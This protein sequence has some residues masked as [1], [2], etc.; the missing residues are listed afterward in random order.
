MGHLIWQRCETKITVVYL[1]NLR[2]SPLLIP[3]GSFILQSNNKVGINYS[4]CSLTHVILTLNWMI[5]MVYNIKPYSKRSNELQLLKSTDKQKHSYFSFNP[6]FSEG[7]F[8]LWSKL[9]LDVTVFCIITFDFHF[10]W[11]I[12]SII[13]TRKIFLNVN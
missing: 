12:I 10:T 6:R 9:Q 11:N 1:C 5:I 3:K 8:S 4:C 7:R 2:G 13:A